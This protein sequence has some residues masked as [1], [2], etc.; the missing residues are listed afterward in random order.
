MSSYKK[1]KQIS[2][3]GTESQRDF[4]RVI[5]ICHD[6]RFAFIQLPRI[7][8]SLFPAIG[9]KVAKPPSLTDRFQKL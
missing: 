7:F 5:L 6:C 3:R 2:H 8:E 9:L 4:S 1:G